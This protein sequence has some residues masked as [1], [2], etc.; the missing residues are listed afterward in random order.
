MLTFLF[1]FSSKVSLAQSN[2]RILLNSM[3]EN[4]KVKILTNPH[5]G[6]FFEKSKYGQ[7]LIWGNMGNCFIGGDFKD[8]P[9]ATRF[10][11]GLGIERPLNRVSIMNADIS[12]SKKGFENWSPHFVQLHIGYNYALLNKPKW[13]CTLGG[14]YI[15]GLMTNKDGAGALIEGS[16]PY[17]SAISFNVKC[18]YRNLFIK[19]GY[20][21]EIFTNFIYPLK[22][23]Q[24]QF[25]IR[26]GLGFF[27]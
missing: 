21:T 11:V 1:F 7:V 8:I 20:E 25:Y 6:S 23:C 5:E 14:E 13:L 19:A 3:G 18:Q 17:T 2:E 12:F 4:S 26:A 15:M 24:Q 22:G 9:S 27:D 10:G 16:L